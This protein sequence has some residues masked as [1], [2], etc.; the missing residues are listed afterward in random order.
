MAV[1][2]SCRKHGTT[3]NAQSLRRNELLLFYSEKSLWK[4][5]NDEELFFGKTPLLGQNHRPMSLSQL[6]IGAF[7]EPFRRGGSWTKRVQFRSRRLSA[8][9]PR[10]GKVGF[11]AGN[12][13]LR[14]SRF[15]EISLS[16][17]AG[18][19]ER[20]ELAVGSA[21]IAIVRRFETWEA[22]SSHQAKAAMAY[23][24]GHLGGCPD[25]DLPGTSS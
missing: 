5:G 21:D 14:G 24:H 10:E 2:E 23:Q 13:L 3:I 11:H 17:R 22:H 15:G 7:E 18:A 25:H 9:F 12:G 19:G 6:Q 8:N 16:A 1:C 20:G 4:E